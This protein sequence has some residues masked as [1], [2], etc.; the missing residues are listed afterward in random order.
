M[1]FNSCFYSALPKQGNKESS[2]CPFCPNIHNYFHM[3]CSGNFKVQRDF[4]LEQYCD[5]LHAI[6]VKEASTDVGVPGRR[7][8]I[9]KNS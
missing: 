7:T 9:F 1:T 4:I 2:L 5:I 8:G 6:M 3:N